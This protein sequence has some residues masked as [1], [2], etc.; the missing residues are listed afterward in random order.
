MV[1]HLQL[2]EYAINTYEIVHSFEKDTP[3]TSNL[4]FKIN[5]IGF[6]SLLK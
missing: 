4:L 5:F 2:L 1:A 6:I 3:R